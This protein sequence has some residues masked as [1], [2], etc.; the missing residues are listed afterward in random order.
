[1]RGKIR[2]R[3]YS[4]DQQWSYRQVGTGPAGQP[5]YNIVNRNS[6]K[7][8][9][10]I[11]GSMDVGGNAVQWDCIGHDDQKWYSSRNL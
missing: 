3:G 9:G 2:G 7:C 8:L 5:A 10:I 6:G 1:M 4:Y 11:G